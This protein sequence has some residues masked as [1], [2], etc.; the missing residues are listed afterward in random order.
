MGVENIFSYEKHQFSYQNIID[1]ISLLDNEM[2]KKFNNIIV[3][4]G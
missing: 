3:K 2:V 4:F 1:N